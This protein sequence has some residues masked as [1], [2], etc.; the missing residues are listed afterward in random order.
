MAGNVNLIDPNEINTRK[1]GN[2]NVNAIPQYQDMY[3]FAEL[4]A[5]S[6][7]RTVIVTSN[8]GNVSQGTFKTGFEKPKEVNFVG[9]NQ[10]EGDNNP[11]YLKFTT[12]YYD[13][14]T[15]MHAQY[16][17]FG[18]TN[19]K[20][21][22]NS[23]FIPQ[24]NIQFVDLRGLSF[25]NQEG[26]PY[27][28]LFDFPPP[29][30]ELSLKGYYGKT[31][32]YKLHLVKYTSE[33]QSDSGNFVIDA[34]FVAITFA[35]LTDV[36]FRYVVNTALMTNPQVEI[37]PSTEAEPPNTFALITQLKNLYTAVTEKTKTDGDSKEYDRTTTRLNDVDNMI[38]MLQS[39]RGDINLLKLPTSYLIM[40]ANNTP[41]GVDDI[42]ENQP[43]IPLNILSEYDQKIKELSTNDIPEKMEDRLYIIIPVQ[44]NQESYAPTVSGATIS[45]QQFIND[46]NDAYD[47]Y[48]KKLIENTANSLGILNS[49]LEPTISKIGFNNYYNVIN[50]SVR[51]KTTR[52]VGIDVTD[53]YLTLYKERINLNKRRVELSEVLTTKI[54]EMVFEKLGMM[55]TIYNI[56]KIILNDVDR[57]FEQLRITSRKAE[58]E[59]HND[60]TNKRIILGYGYKDIIPGDT[61]K[62]YAFPLVVNT[63]KTICGGNKEEKIAPI[64]I[65]QKTLTPFPEIDFV[66]DFI[67]TFFTQARLDYL[68][69]MRE[70]QNDDGTYE[71]IPISPFDSKLGTFNAKS[72]YYDVDVRTNAINTSELKR[73]GQVFEIVLKR[74]YILSQSSI[75][76]SF[77]STNTNSQ[78][79]S[80]Y[81]KMYATSEAINLASS[82]IN[83]NYIDNLREFSNKYRNN[84]PDF[85]LE[86]EKQIPKWYGFPDNTET[87]ID[88]VTGD[89][90]AYIDKSNP[91]YLGVNILFDSD[92]E[93]QTVNENSEK[94]IDRFK[95]DVKKRK[96]WKF[97][98]QR[99][100]E[101]YYQFTQQNTLY[102]VDKK[103]KADGQ[104]A[105]ENINDSDGNNLITRY[106]SYKS[107]PTLKYPN[108]DYSTYTPTSYGT[109]GGNVEEYFP[110]V[111]YD[112]TNLISGG[113]AYLDKFSSGAVSSNLK[114]FEKITDVW[115]NQLSSRYFTDGQQKYFDDLIYEDIIK[116]PSKLSALFILS[117]FGNALG[118]FNRFP[119][120]LNDLVFTT[121]AAIEIP[122]YL[123]LYI[124]ALVDASMS[125]WGNEIVEYFTGGTGKYFYDRSV[126]ILCDYSDVNKYLSNKDKQKFRDEFLDYFSNGSS[127]GA[128]YDTLIRFQQLYYAVTGNT[129][130]NKY[131]VY[132]SY[133]DPE[134]DVDVDTRYY[135]LLLKSLIE[136]VNL[137]VFSQ[138]TFKMSNDYPDTYQSIKS[139]NDDDTDMGKAKQR[140]NE[141]YF[142]KFLNELYNQIE[143]KRADAIKKENEDNKKKNDEDVITQTYYSF[144]NINDKWLTG[145]TN[146]KTWG[147]PF[148]RENKKLIDSFV[149]VD[150]AMNPAGDTM[151]NA[152][153][154]IDLFDDPNVSVFSVLSQLLSLNGFEFFPLQNFMIGDGS[155]EECFE[156]DTSGSIDDR[157][158]FVCMYIGGTSSYPTSV[159]NGFVNDGIEDL[160]N[161][162]VKDFSTEECPPYPK[163]D[164][165]LSENAD[166]PYHTVRAFRVRFGEQ[167]QS[168]FTNIKI[169]S[170]EYPET[171][172]SI[173]ILSRLAGD[174]KE[175]AIPKGQNLYNLYENRS[176]KATVT[177]LGN[178]M[179]QP[180]QY[181]QLENIP[182]FNGAYIILSVEHD[183]SANKMTTS[184]SGTKIL[185]YPIP[186]VTQPLAFMGYDGGESRTTNIQEM[187]GG[188]L[189]AAA[190]VVD[191]E[192]KAQFNSM[193]NFKIQ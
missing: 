75:P 112:Y 62:I 166:F 111:D 57:F 92:L 15:G 102:I 84:I 127:N 185:K 52:Y 131:K 90:P 46:V 153:I 56:F 13:G 47:K 54:N 137:I 96:W 126:L 100:K 89:E 151:L 114:K 12:N 49:K 68:A 188:Q 163:N 116:T 160:S 134:S 182:L 86:L 98:S 170:K 106:L 60:E 175:H 172:E 51:E 44:Y 154:L 40:K 71:W 42:E 184:F 178:M 158:A 69:N 138:N 74:F 76:N 39:Y 168:M 129:E 176:Y 190:S 11:N 27:R 118:V 17:S 115:I 147:Y 140:I 107:I 36:L 38:G 4:K 58:N 28:I 95:S 41:D 133:L 155:W 97:L 130:T 125:G 132:K 82:A 77:Y 149:F 146:T 145:P 10:N 150:R 72:P 30:F 121:P 105:K 179:I 61:G 104:I 171:N 67:Q 167:N 50:R 9:I 193:Y 18:I 20:V 29:I 109:Y 183:I 34:Q 157:P 16:E 122:K 164:N 189:V 83:S 63:E 191:N 135:P 78:T 32:R 180:T 162:D 8:D 7:A 59:H 108:V 66:N 35:P 81:V 31:L 177:G 14:S 113:N 128:Y 22:V 85:Y 142:T 174:N 148:N 152:E 23:S 103:L 70:S 45:N 192:Q 21:I 123:A 37:S 73:I 48:A 110:R 120:G 88:G 139:M 93:I 26:S 136:R 24:V 94:P 1:K 159:Q 19:I 80:E 169:D 144:K 91:E 173:Q 186:R 53:F 65:S 101:V 43:I 119:C 33:F 5:K 181:F 141:E 25:F 143:N 55:P 6:R 165:Q 2:D 87:N 156:I 99:E 79:A 161:V 3:I 117:N 187:S 124:G 64:G